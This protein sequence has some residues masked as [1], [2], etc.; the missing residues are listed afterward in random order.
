MDDY[1]PMYSY[2]DGYKP[3]RTP[4]QC[5]GTLV[6][7]LH[8]YPNPEDV[9]QIKS[10]IYYINE[11]K[12]LSEKRNYVRFLPCICGCNKRTHGYS[13]NNDVI[14]KCMRCDFEVSGKNEADA[15]RNWNKVICDKILEDI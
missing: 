7:Y 6:G 5:V 12:R 1:G 14:L 11:Y 8:M 15:K 3:V 10:M 13:F 9:N 2:N 4:D